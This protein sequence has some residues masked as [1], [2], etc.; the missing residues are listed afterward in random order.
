MFK[1]ILAEF[2]WLRINS[3]AVDPTTL[4]T[5]VPLDLEVTSSV[6][7]SL[8]ILEQTLHL[9][10]RVSFGLK[11]TFP[12][13]VKKFDLLLFPKTFGVQHQLYF[14]VENRLVEVLP[15]WKHRSFTVCNQS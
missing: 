2:D 14:G 8:I 5:L 15:D 13:A 10:I 12:A 7:V 11:A 1:S 9:G 4:T 6:L 3:P